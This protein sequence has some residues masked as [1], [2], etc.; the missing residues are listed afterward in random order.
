M[1]VPV[2]A[3]NWK[4]NKTLAE[5]V[6]FVKGL[7]PALSPFRGIECVVAPSFVALAAVADALAGTALKVSA[8]QIHYEQEGAFTSQISALMLQGIADYAIIG[9][10]ECRQYLAE[11]DE[12]VNKKLK[13]ALAASIIPIVA[14]GETIEQ[15]RA[16][17]ADS[18]VSGQLMAA[19]AGVSADQVQTVIVAYEPIWAIGTGES[20]TPDIAAHMCGTV[21]RGTLRQ[22]FGDI[23]DHMRIQ[24]G[25]S[26]KPDNMQAY[27]SVKDIDGA[28]VGNASLKVESFTELIR[29]A[30]ETKG[31]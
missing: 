2:I 10:S 15:R 12:T 5:S 28:L 21:V 11:T 9:H 13:S 4:M 24:Y 22:L 26:V 1:R 23:A 31:I 16:G 19:F 8:Q 27:M 6:A 7:E 14:V 29:I 20:A 3:G 18:F 17:E 30:A 25:G